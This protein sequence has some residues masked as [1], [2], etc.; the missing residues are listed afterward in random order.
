MG[1]VAEDGNVFAPQGLDDKIADHATVVR[2]HTRAIGIEDSDNF[3]VDM[4]L[5]VI[6]HH[7]AFSGALAFVIA[8]PDADGVDPAPVIFFLGMDLGI[9]VDLGGRGLENGGP[10]P[11]G[12]AQGVDGAHD[13]GFNRFDGV[14]LVMNGGGG[15]GQVVDFLNLE[16]YRIDDI[17]ADQLEMRVGQKVEN[18]VFA[19]CEEIVQADDVVALR[20]EM[21][22][23]MR[24]EKT[25]AAGDKDT[26]HKYSS[27]L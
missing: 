5:P 1:T 12:Q 10:D 2:G 14:V 9:A 22:A 17:V 19:A 11:F 24:A 16:K 3:D 25:G 27:A 8:A 20:K 21:F 15:A 4:V 18:V 23:E 6:I 7:E 13:V 26:F